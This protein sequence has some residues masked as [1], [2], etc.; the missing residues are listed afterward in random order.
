ML[1]CPKA[2]QMLQHRANYGLRQ[3]HAIAVYGTQKDEQKETN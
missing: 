1:V 3:T 2:R